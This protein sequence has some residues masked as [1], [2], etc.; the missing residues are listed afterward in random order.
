MS[1][2]Q[3][4]IECDTEYFVMSIYKD[5][6]YKKSFEE[7]NDALTQAEIMAKAGVKMVVVEEI[8]HNMIFDA[9]LFYGDEH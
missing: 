7:L 2:S 4:L 9:W 6:D 3:E 8:R 5:C 1:N